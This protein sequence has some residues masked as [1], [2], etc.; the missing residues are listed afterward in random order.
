[1]GNFEVLFM[2]RCS[3]VLFLLAGLGFGAQTPS[4]L[5]TNIPGRTTVSLNGAWRVIVDPFDN[6]KSRFFLD[7]K[8]K[9]KRDLVEYSFDDSP[10]INV[11]GDWNT[12]RE[13]LMFYEG[14]VWYKRAFNYRKHDGKRVFVHF[15]AVNYQASVYLNG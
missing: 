9:D 3:L 10:V 14:T 12:Q 4:T 11:P 13:S 1:M 6:G 8:P 5:I 2:I 15:G 7:V